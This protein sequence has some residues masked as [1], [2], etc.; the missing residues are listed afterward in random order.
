MKL[1]YYGSGNPFHP[2]SGMDVVLRGHLLEVADGT[3]PPLVR[4]V[5]R[6]MSETVPQGSPFAGDAHRV[7]RPGRLRRPGHLAAL[8][9]K[10]AHVLRGRPLMTIG[11]AS[12][13]AERQFKAD[14]RADRA[15]FV[16]D[17]L[18]SATNMPLW[19]LLLSRHRFVYVCHDFTVRTLIDE[20]ALA[21]SPLRKLSKLAQSAQVLLAECVLIAKSHR[22]VF[23]SSA[24]R[25]R[26]R[27]LC[28]GK[29]ETLNP[30]L[31][32]SEPTAADTIADRFRDEDL[33]DTT[34]FV[35]SPGFAPNAYA[36]EWLRDRL[37]PA[38]QAV[39]A[40]VRL[41]LVGKGTE[42]IPAPGDPTLRGTGFVTDA[43]LQTI[44]SRCLCSISPVVHGSG[45]K[46]KL[47]EAFAAGCPVVATASSLRGFDFVEGVPV[48]SIDNP[49]A[50]AAILMHLRE[51]REAGDDGRDAIRERWARHEASRIGRLRQVVHDAID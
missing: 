33:S 22:V 21:R 29:S 51:R 11:Y 28:D 30:L 44:L 20:A 23:I 42:R 14:L 6:D 39:G 3:P 38:L 47:L 17:H 24:D 27:W 5:L 43:E 26:F 4:I 13:E 48:I 2:S 31:D 12:G 35:G 34:V 8:R 10:L 46:I 49:S 37:A 9:F 19:R 16:V 1:F 41:L 32:R 45:L 15:V 50:A 36:I 7:F 25:A 18:Q 40:P